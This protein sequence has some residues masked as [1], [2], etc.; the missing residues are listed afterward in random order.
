MLKVAKKT[1]LSGV[2]DKSFNNTLGRDLHEI[3][4]QMNKPKQA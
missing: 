4:F 2:F 1:H 3:Q